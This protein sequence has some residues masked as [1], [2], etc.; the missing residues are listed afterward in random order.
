MRVKLAV[1]AI[2]AVGLAVGGVTLASAHPT[3]SSDDHG[4]QV[5]TVF[6]VTVQSE[7][8]DLGPQ[9]FSLGDQVVFADDVY[10]HKGG[11]KIGTDGVVCT[12]VRVTD[13]A[14]GSG[15]AQCVAT[16]QLADGQIT[17]QGFNS[18]TGDELPAPFQLAITGG[19]GAYAN[20]RGQVTVEELSETEA[21]I[22]LELRTG[23]HH[24]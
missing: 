15:T 10:D 1:A 12:V 8:L 16:A 21:N 11:T 14:T 7:S 2:C 23:K 3:G 13:A 18:F 22:T 17:V 9:G 24:H 6:T 19:T 20:A 5:F 4:T